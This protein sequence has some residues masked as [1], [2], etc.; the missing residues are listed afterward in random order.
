[1]GEGPAPLK[2]LFVSAE[3][4]PFAKT[5]GLADVGGALPRALRARGI[6]VRVVTPLYAGM[7]WDALERLEG[8]VPVPMWWGTAQAGVRL[9]RLPRSD[10]PV[11]FLE[12]HRYFDRP[13]LYGPPGEA[14][15]DNLE[16]FAFL[17]R[18]ALELAKALNFLPDVIH[19]NDWQTALVP[20]Y[21]NTVEWAR[22]LH[23]AGTVYTIHNMAYQG[24]TDGNALF[25]TGLG[26]EHYN[27]AEFEHFGAL[28]L[29]KA[30]LRHANVLSTVSPTYARE[31]QTPAYGFG[32][33]GVLRERAGDLFGILNGIDAEEWDPATDPYIPEDFS[34]EDL[35]GK[36]ACKAALQRE[37]R[38]AV[39]PGVPV[40]GTVG[41]L[42][43]QKGFD[44]LANCL[45]RVLSW[46]LQLV[47]LGTGDR[48]AEHFFGT[49]SALRPDRFKAWIGFDNGL[50]HRI[51][52]GSDFFLM[53][54]R[55]EPSGLNQMYSLRYGT[56]PIV[57]ATGGLADTVQGYR[58]DTGEGTGFMFQDL[59]PDA[60]ANTIGWA[61]ST[62]H[63]RPQHIAAMRRRAMAQDFSWDA[64]AVAY[65]RLYLEA[66]RRRRGHGFPAAVADAG[67]PDQAASRPKSEPAPPPARPA[68]KRSR[69]PVG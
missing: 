63:D 51:E 35:S 24:V 50:A 42:T 59:T 9:G 26:R 44:V 11:Y 41:R 58:E 20:V 55:F 13:F 7:D 61:L 10:A 40:L 66:Y 19:A 21:V 54:S 45:D 49:L 68:R 25:I 22:P 31:I 5:G 52:A 2:V 53:P 23:G 36:A 28:N 12:Y 4:A 67:G 18:G 16:R 43:D 34:A 29:M 47:M 3:V 46:D 62:W 69:R 15:D 57:R 6:D 33:D 30:A 64:A 1:M 27:P 14:Y 38:L 37:A 17:S 39:D 60:L 56:L 32:L 48:T 8:A 65:E